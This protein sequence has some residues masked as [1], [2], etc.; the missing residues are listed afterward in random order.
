MLKLRLRTLVVIFFVSLMVLITTSC[1]STTKA[2]TAVEASVEPAVDSVDA[3]DEL[4]SR[5]KYYL[6]SEKEQIEA[7]KDSDYSNFN[8]GIWDEYEILKFMLFICEDEPSSWF[9]YGSM[10]QFL[11]TSKLTKNKSAL[12]SY[13]CIPGAGSTGVITIA[14]QENDENKIYKTSSHICNLEKKQDSNKIKDLIDL[15]K[16]EAEKY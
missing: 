12:I 13:Y 9:P 3:E 4:S 6:L 10:S 11:D 14:I 5:D 8:Y 7:S 2:T 15:I 16:K 1:G